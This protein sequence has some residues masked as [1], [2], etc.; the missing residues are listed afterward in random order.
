MY[1]PKEILRLVAGSCPG[2]PLEQKST[3]AGM[4]PMPF[5][6]ARFKSCEVLVV[7]SGTRSRVF[8]WSGTAQWISQ[9]QH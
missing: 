1:L 2:V 7:L 9:L 5:G 3:G 8:G 4:Q 6:P